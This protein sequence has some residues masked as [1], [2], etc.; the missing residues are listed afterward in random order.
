MSRSKGN[1]HYNYPVVMKYLK[2]NDVVYA[3]YADGQHLRI[4][5]AV[6]IIDLWPSRMTYHVIKS[7]KPV[8][9]DEYRRLN[10]YADIKELDKLLNE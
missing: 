5:G 3:E 4:M 2:D 7:E 1:F 9:A 6:S 10:I 8:R